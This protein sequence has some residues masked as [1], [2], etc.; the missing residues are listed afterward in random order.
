MS[1]TVVVIEAPGKIKSVSKILGSLRFNASV[2]A[3]GGILYDMP[4]KKLGLSPDNLVPKEWVPVSAKTIKFL[5]KRFQDAKRI[6][7]MTD[8]D[9]EGELI[10]AQVS[11]L[12]KTTGF[13][14]TIDRVIS[15]AINADAI[16][17]ALKTPMPISRDT[18][19]GVMARRGIDRAI[20]F[21]CS[22][23]SAGNQIAGRVSSKLLAAINATPLDTCKLAGSH[24]QQPGWRIS[25][26]GTSK[27]KESLKA[28]E[29]AFKTLNPELMSH[30]K[31]IH[32]TKPS[33][34]LLNGSDTLLLV[35]SQLNVS[36][37]EA[38]DLIQSSYE[39]GAISYPRTDSR[40]I[41]E[42]TSRMLLTEMRTAGMRAANKNTSGKAP[43][44]AQGAHEAVYPCNP[45]SSRGSGLRGLSKA[46]SVAAIVTGRTF[47]SLSPDAKVTSTVVDQA[48]ISRFL[49]SQK[50]PDV[51]VRIW[52]D[53]PETAGWL[54]LEKEFVRP[55]G[56]SEIPMDQAIL[57]RL[58]QSGIGRPSTV[59]GHISKALQR[60]WVSQDTGMLTH[61]GQ[62]VLSFIEQTYPSLLTSP[63][64]DAFLES[65]HF[66]SLPEAVKGGI[67]RIGLDYEDLR[68]LARQA[69]AEVTYEYTQEADD[70]GLPVY[71]MSY[72]DDVSVQFG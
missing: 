70:S 17:Q 47:A 25:A 39:R 61:K 40:A 65:V 37:Q 11:S 62:A 14:G 55:A 42:P 1:E 44:F 2:V 41:S 31:E 12:A 52:R 50:L 53:V 63:D 3:T 10:A 38:E 35:A 20:G 58:V 24:S 71:E 51:K 67:A 5:E 64:L 59:V 9:R 4:Q 56:M 43:D 68:N 27:T 34:A 23:P 54:T 66:D 33:P 30:V 7:V 46:D 60:N 8:G 36:L 57:E 13:T 21:L 22:N 18:C 32:T 49:K 19:I 72:E 45:S 69:T 28:I 16:S 15:S 29:Q 26:R 48:A 6:V